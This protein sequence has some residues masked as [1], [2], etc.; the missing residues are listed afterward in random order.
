MKLPF[1]CY[2]HHFT[3]VVGTVVQHF[4]RMDMN[5][6]GY[7]IVNRRV[8]WKNPDRFP[9][10]IC[11]CITSFSGGGYGTTTPWVMSVYEKVDV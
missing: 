5:H 11:N 7:K 6:N 1:D 3:K 8:D 10:E 9:V 2:N 4:S